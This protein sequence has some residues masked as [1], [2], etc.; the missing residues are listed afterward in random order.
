MISTGK[1]IKRLKEVGFVPPKSK[2]KLFSDIY[3]EVQPFLAERVDNVDD[4]KAA[5]FAITLTQDA[6][7]GRSL[8][9]LVL[10]EEGFLYG[11]AMIDE[12]SMKVIGFGKPHVKKMHLSVNDDETA[13]VGWYFKSEGRAYSFKAFNQEIP[14]E[15]LR[16]LATLESEYD[17]GTNLREMPLMIKLLTEEEV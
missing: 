6:H 9:I 13:F 10:V 7:W 16:E 11:A 3:K 15:F 17:L 1:L 12:D 2:E 14:L 4:I 5:F 8:G